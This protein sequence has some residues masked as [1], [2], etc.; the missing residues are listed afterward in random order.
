MHLAS[1]KSLGIDGD[2]IGV[3]GTVLGVLEEG[4]MEGLAS[5]A[6]AWMLHSLFLVW[7]SLQTRH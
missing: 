3:D 6:L 7:R 5:R 4:Y 2:A 1:C